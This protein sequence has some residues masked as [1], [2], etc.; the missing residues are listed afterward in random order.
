[1]IELA[2]FSIIATVGTI[3]GYGIAYLTNSLINKRKF[4]ELKFI[5]DENILEVLKSEEISKKNKQCIVCNKK[6]MKNNIGMIVSKNNKNSFTCNNNDC[7][8]VSD[9]AIQRLSP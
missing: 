9:F 3:S 1:M 5:K 6:I 2:S 4:T 8:V 7:M